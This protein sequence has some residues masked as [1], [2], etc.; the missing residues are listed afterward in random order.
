MSIGATQ[1]I[2]HAAGPL[3]TLAIVILFGV[4]FGGLAKAI[5][6]PSV[7]GQILA[8]VLIGEVGFDLFGDEPVQGLQPLTHFAL[9]L[10]AFTVGSHLNVRRLR[11]AGK[12][13][14]CCC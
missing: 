8:G 10:I 7:P 14:F 4:A 5:R 6:L 2:L 12:R 9:G 13:L 11:N 1:P 3:L